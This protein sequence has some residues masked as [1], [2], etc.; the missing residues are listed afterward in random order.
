MCKKTLAQRRKS[1]IKR[2]RKEAALGL[3]HIPEKRFHQF[4]ELWTDIMKKE[5]KKK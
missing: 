5:E 2:V 4:L 3:A 1:F